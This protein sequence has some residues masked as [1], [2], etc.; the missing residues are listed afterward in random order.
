MAQA[1]IMF[2][3]SLSAA[4][5]GLSGTGV[6]MVPAE[7]PTT[8]QEWAV[9]TLSWTVSQN[10]DNTWHYAYTLSVSQ[11]NIKQLIIESSPMLTEAG[12][13]NPVATAGNY[14]RVKVDNVDYGTI[15]APY[16]PQSVYG[17]KFARATGVELA[18]QFDSVFAPIWGDAYARGANAGGMYTTLWNSGFV[19][20]DPALAA[21]DGS[22]GN[23]VLVPGGLT[24]GG[25]EIPEPTTML[26]LGIGSV[27]VLL[28]RRRLKALV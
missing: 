27:A 9:P 28:R 8:D 26:L 13:L 12:V 24:F 3:G 7:T 18:V 19:D 4:D 25:G 21:T 14:A 5:G 2:S 10:E 22:N 1:A 20:S 16:L 15:S 17:I 23:H 11:S 6:W